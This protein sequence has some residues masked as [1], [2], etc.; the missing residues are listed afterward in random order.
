MNEEEDPL[1]KIRERD[2]DRPTLT[3]FIV[4][5]VAK[6]GSL[7][8]VIYILINFAEPLWRPVYEILKEIFAGAPGSTPGT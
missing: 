4:I 8:L 2:R 1:R 6:W 5:E 7:L 3:S